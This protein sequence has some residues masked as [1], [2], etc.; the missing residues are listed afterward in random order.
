MV[1]IGAGLL[2]LSDCF[3]LNNTTLCGLKLLRANVSILNILPL[4]ITCTC[5]ALNV[6]VNVGVSKLVCCNSVGAVR[7]LPLLTDA[8]MEYGFY[9]NNV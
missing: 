1:G 7:V 8:N 6:A 3:V 9:N 4:Q 2:I 5:K